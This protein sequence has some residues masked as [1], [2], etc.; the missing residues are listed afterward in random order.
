MAPTTS[1][2]HARRGDNNGG[3]QEAQDDQDEPWSFVG[4]CVRDFSLGASAASSRHSPGGPGGDDCDSSSSDDDD[5]DANLGGI[6]KVKG[7]EKYDPHSS[8]ERL[9]AFWSRVSYNSAVHAHLSD[10]AE[11]LRAYREGLSQQARWDEEMERVKAKLGEESEWKFADDAA[12]KQREKLAAQAAER[13]ARAMEEEERAEQQQRQQQQ[14]HRNRQHQHQ[15]HRHEQQQTRPS[16]IATWLSHE[17]QFKAF[18]DDPPS[19]V[20]V[21]VVPWP[22]TP[23]DHILA[24]PA[25]ILLRGDRDRDDPEVVL[26]AYRK[27]FRALALRW[28]PDKFEQMFG[29]RVDCCSPTESQKVR[30]RVQSLAQAIQ[31][32]W[33]ACT[34][35]H[36]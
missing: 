33:D 34:N 26:R 21:N 2:S 8:S 28:H 32:A 35:T 17:E 9:K 6:P 12:T 27:A 31:A 24:A 29:S 14:Q 20:D 13:V 30:E 15:Q 22:P 4:P 3:A 16:A 1:M 19:A 36:E 10:E 5:N 23:W 11:R 18:A 7:K 25:A